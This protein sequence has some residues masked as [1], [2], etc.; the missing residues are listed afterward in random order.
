MKRAFEWNKAAGRE[1]DKPFG[2]SSLSEWC[3]KYGHD[4]G[5]VLLKAV[6]MQL[7]EECVYEEF[8]R[9]RASKQPFDPA[10]HARAQKRL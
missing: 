4:E 2:C 9:D 5:K 1:R 7:V 3:E 6:Q 8:V 10:R